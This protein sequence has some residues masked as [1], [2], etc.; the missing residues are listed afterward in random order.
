MADCGPKPG[1]GKHGVPVGH[2]Q[3]VLARIVS[4]L[5]ISVAQC[6][7]NRMADPPTCSLS[8]Y[9]HCR[10]ASRHSDCRNVGSKEKSSQ[11]Y[12]AQA[13]R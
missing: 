4:S 11:V 6:A 12:G 8:L 7:H 9:V 5:S 3:N 10:Y 2:H 13:G 1:T